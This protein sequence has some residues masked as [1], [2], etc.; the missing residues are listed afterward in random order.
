MVLQIS[1]QPTA[2]QLEILVSE[3]HGVTC[4]PKIHAEV[5]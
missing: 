5:V 3:V 4:M 2:A 1:V